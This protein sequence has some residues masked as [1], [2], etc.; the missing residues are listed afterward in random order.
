MCSVERSIRDK[1]GSENIEAN[2]RNKLGFLYFCNSK[3][4]RFED[5][6]R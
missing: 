3:A 2:I 5:N 6:A 4:S 1:F